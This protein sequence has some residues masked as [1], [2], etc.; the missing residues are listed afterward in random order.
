MIIPSIDLMDGKAVQLEQGKTKRLECDKIWELA[1]NF[2]Q[3]GDIAVIDLDAALDQGN[4]FD[5]VVELC[6][7]F[8][9]RVGGGIR[10]IAR[11]RQILKAGAK[12]IIIGT[13]ATPEFLKQLPKH[14][15][16]VAIDGKRGRVLTEGWRTETQ[17]SPLERMEALADFCSEFLYTDVEIEGM[18]QGPNW[19]KIHALVKQSPHP[20]TIAGSIT[21]TQ[22]ILRLESM[23]A[24]SQIG[25]SLYTNQLDLL[26]TF[27]TMLDFEK[28]QGLIPTIVQDEQKNVL[29]LAYSSPTS[30]QKTFQSGVA[31]Y[32]SRSKKKLWQKGET[33]GNFQR[34]LRA[35]YDCDRD[36]LL[37]TVK[38]TGVAC[39]TGT[40][41]CFDDQPFSIQELYQVIQ[42][43]MMNPRPESYTSSIGESET[44]IMAKIQEEAQEVIN[45][46]NRDNLIWEIGD[47]LYFALILMV[48]K[49][50]TPQEILNELA[51]RQKNT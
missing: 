7:R 21:T 39:H 32:F 3:Y 8:P 10:S 51:G 48:S 50:I 14:K 5:T 11:A 17:Q 23:G 46:R 27:I 49:K 18:M 25:M 20:I 36:T 43:R 45:Y 9:C 12:K 24:N 29:M 15:I 26:P 22:D 37:F 16:I 31:W 44:K 6:K 35:R 30:L 40:Y 33:S 38:Q 19:D 13:K 42:D 28:Q 34:F 4:N 2:Q 47:L 41:S 1:K